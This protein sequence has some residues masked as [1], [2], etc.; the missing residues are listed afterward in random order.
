MGL[1]VGLALASETRVT[2]QQ[3][4]WQPAHSLPCAFPPLQQQAPNILDRGCFLLLDPKEVTR[5]F[6]DING[7]QGINFIIWHYWE[8]GRGGCTCY[9]AYPDWYISLNM[10]LPHGPFGGSLFLMDESQTFGPDIKPFPCSPIH[11][12]L[13]I[14]HSPAQLFPSLSPI[15]FLGSVLVKKVS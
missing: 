14:P 10:S 11:R 8:R 7:E 15:Y 9:K 2:C 1:A 5:L 12:A 13:H 6:V 4:F 3:K